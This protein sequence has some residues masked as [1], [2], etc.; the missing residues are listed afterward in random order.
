MPNYQNIY[1]RLQEYYKLFSNNSETGFV[2]D[3]NYYY[4]MPISRIHELT[5]IP[6]E[7]IRKDIMGIHSWKY[8]LE[9]DDDIQEDLSDML[10][11]ALDSDDAEFDRLLLDGTFDQVPIYLSETKHG[12]YHIRLTRDEA[13]AYHHYQT[14]DNYTPL[15]FAGY[16]IKDSYR[17]NYID[18]LSEKLELL[19]SAINNNSCVRITYSP[20]HSEDF[21][22]IIKP[23]KIVYDSIDNMYA[24]LTIYENQIFVY[25]LDRLKDLAYSRQQILID[26]LDLLNIAPNVWGFEFSSK[27]QKVKIRFYNEGNVW[28]KV[29]KDL[30]Y[31]TN[32]LL[33]EQDGFLYYE[34]IVYGI[35]S[36]RT[37]IY[38]YGSSAIVLEPVELRKH[39]IESL[40]LRKESI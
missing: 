29:R 5:Q 30:S 22:V 6:L 4:G 27:P 19:N 33:Y 13:Y 2:I 7:V 36:F 3:E 18:N 31:R 16:Q 11:D 39:I 34:D 17:Y 38:G 9:Y 12:L 28:K 15:H 10:N 35:N 25:R 23:L 26:S 14:Q 40:K 37:W 24:V 1:E 8:L 32:G 21:T 20:P